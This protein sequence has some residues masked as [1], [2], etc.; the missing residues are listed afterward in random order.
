MYVTAR[1]SMTLH[2]LTHYVKA[3]LQWSRT[4]RAPAPV[5]VFG[6]GVSDVLSYAFR[7]DDE[8]AIP[9]PSIYV[10]REGDEGYDSDWSL[11]SLQ[12]V[13]DSESE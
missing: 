11:P 9:D 8:A 1:L 3:Y 6:A 2:I 13:S 5:P 4:W 7:V 12:S 10:L